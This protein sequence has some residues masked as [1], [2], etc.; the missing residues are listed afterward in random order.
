MKFLVSHSKTVC[1]AAL[2]ALGLAG[3]LGVPQGAEPVRGFE[4]D[5]Y[6]GK[7]YEIARLDHPF[8]RG[9]SNVTAQYSLREDGGVRVVNRGFKT[10]DGEWEEADG[11][12]YF[13]DD[14]SVGML[15]VSFFGPFYGAYNVIALDKQDYLWSLV[16]GPD[17][18]YLWILSREP[19]LDKDI[20]DELVAR[21]NTLGFDT[22][23]LIIVDQ[24]QNLE[25]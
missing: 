7:W 11:K 10:A 8:E 9:L 4:L 1:L 2:L 19:R 20:F 16:V 13:V 18:D 17:T 14:P 6:L 3:C 22:G 23:Q 21:A 24:A 25:P 15:K 12:A 5:R